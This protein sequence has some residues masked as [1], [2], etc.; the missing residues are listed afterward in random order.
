MEERQ[1]ERTIS[2]Q[3]LKQEREARKLRELEQ[4]IALRAKIAAERM[5]P[6]KDLLSKYSRLS[7]G[8]LDGQEWLSFDFKER[9]R[10]A[11]A[12]MTIDEWL[13]YEPENVKLQAAVAAKMPIMEWL[14]NY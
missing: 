1:V 9:A 10:A 3:T 11:A 2:N 12:G 5:A 7:P 13:A 4:E 8:V 14:M 6:P